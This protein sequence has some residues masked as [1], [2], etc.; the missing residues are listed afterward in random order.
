MHVADVHQQVGEEDSVHHLIDIVRVR[1]DQQDGIFRAIWHGVKAMGY[2]WLDLMRP[3]FSGIDRRGYRPPLNGGYFALEDLESLRLIEMEVERRCLN[4]SSVDVTWKQVGY[5]SKVS[6]YLR[7]T[8]ALFAEGVVVFVRCSYQNSG[9][10]SVKGF[11]GVLLALLALRLTLHLSR[12]VAPRT[13][14]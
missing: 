4:F 3:V 11:E 2:P 14:K 8:F 7:M 13:P 6:T 5:P 9:S 1:P 12:D 10:R